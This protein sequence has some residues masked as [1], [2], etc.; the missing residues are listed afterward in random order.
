MSKTTRPNFGDIL[1]SLNYA[2]NTYIYKKY[3]TI[4]ATSISS[5]WSLANIWSRWQTAVMGGDITLDVHLY[6]KR[7]FD[8]LS[9]FVIF[10]ANQIS[11]QSTHSATES[12]HM[13]HMNRVPSAI[14][15]CWKKMKTDWFSCWRA[16]AT[17]HSRY[18]RFKSAALFIKIFE[19]LD[20][21]SKKIKLWRRRKKHRNMQHYL[22]ILDV[23]TK[24]KQCKR[25]CE[26]GSLC[27]N[28][29]KQI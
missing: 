23:R 27:S 14:F 10:N 20:I 11:F 2:K 4:R 17:Y 21:L 7:R 18:Y 6:L 3:P 15:E 22:N 25:D 12:M 5:N 1:G 29:N 24:T 16:L 8:C 28:C 13:I 19:K 9:T 26:R